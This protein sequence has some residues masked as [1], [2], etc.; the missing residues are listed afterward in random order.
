MA[1][2]RLQ[3]FHAVAKHLSF[4][5]AADAL[6]MTQPAV[7]FQI[8]QLEEYFSTRLFDRAQGRITLTPAGVIALEYAERII[9]LSAEL[10]ARLKD[11][12]GQLG[13]PRRHRPLPAKGRRA[14]GLPQ[15]GGR[16]RQP[17]GAERARRHGP[18][19][20]HHVARDRRQ[21][22]RARAARPDPPQAA[23]AAQFFGGLPE[24]KISFQA[25]GELPAVRPGAA[26]RHAPAR[27][28]GCGAPA[29]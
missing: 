1:D 7:T 21:G 27:P 12:S 6:F 10:E 11:I 8:K 18:G 20:R 9:A 26:G 13:G 14:A 16:A 28:R 15:R 5:K 22:A 24:G 3:V 17:G 19:L 23:A 29:G 25:G 2:R 4:T